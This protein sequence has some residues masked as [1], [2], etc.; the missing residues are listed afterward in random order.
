MPRGWWLVRAMP[1]DEAA[2]RLQGRSAGLAR[3]CFLS[4]T[5]EEES[6][7]APEKR[8]RRAG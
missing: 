4:V 3:R 8:C 7:A 2:A 1:R 6:A 5:L